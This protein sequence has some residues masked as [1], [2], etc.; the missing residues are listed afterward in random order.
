MEVGNTV[1]QKPFFARKAMD[2]I[3][4]DSV[5][6]AFVSLWAQGLKFVLQTSSVIIMARLLTPQDFGLQGMVLAVTGILALFS[7]VGLGMATIQREVITREQASTLFWISVGVGA[8]LALLVRRW[9][10][11]WLPFIMSRACFG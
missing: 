11:Q 4:R 8:A 6:G 5:R 7:D 2:Q 3:K 9:L 10:L 1:S